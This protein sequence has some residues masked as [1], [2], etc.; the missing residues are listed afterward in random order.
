LFNDDENKNIFND[1]VLEERNH[2]R[3]LEDEFYQLSNKGLIIW[4]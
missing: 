4:D 3:I 2:Q 1:L